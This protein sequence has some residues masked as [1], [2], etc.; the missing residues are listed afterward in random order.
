MEH[1]SVCKSFLASIVSPP[2]FLSPIISNR[3][4]AQQ[5]NSAFASCRGTQLTLKDDHT[6][7]TGTTCRLQTNLQQLQLLFSLQGVWF[8]SCSC[9]IFQLFTRGTVM[10][11]VDTCAVRLFTAASSPIVTSCCR[12]L[13]LL[14]MQLYEH[15]KFMAPRCTEQQLIFPPKFTSENGF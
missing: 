10:G 3:L 13:S 2:L 8:G 14:Y 5:H 7:M 11:L 15:E 9:L 4:P 6:A 1:G 12:R